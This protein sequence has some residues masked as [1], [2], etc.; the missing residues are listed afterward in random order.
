MTEE[1][2]FRYILESNHDVEISGTV[3][4][5][6][7]EDAEDSEF[8][9]EFNRAGDSPSWNLFVNHYGV[10]IRGRTDEQNAEIDELKEIFTSDFLF[11]TRICDNKDTNCVIELGKAY[12]VIGGTDF[13]TWVGDH[14]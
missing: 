11:F 7:E 3:H 12:L 8:E 2:T 5:P 6:E 10:D 14:P 13:E 1:V 9:I 4:I